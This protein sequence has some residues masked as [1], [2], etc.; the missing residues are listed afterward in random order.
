MISFMQKSLKILRGHSFLD[1]TK[2]CLLETSPKDFQTNIDLRNFE[3]KVSK[4]EPGSVSQLTV[5]PFN[6]ML[7]IVLTFRNFSGTD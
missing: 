4:V 6:K 1:L 7:T 3:S 5:Q 2:M